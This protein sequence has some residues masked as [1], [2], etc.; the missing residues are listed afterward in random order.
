M[1]RNN[2]S[3]VVHKPA[4]PA[5]Q[6]P[7]VESIQRPSLGQ[8]MKEGFGLGIGVSVAQHAVNGVMNFFT[9]PKSSNPVENQKVIEYEKCMKYTSNDV[10]TCKSLLDN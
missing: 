6:K 5:A 7:A 2:K 4:S 1:A 9:V 3:I 8:S 10:D